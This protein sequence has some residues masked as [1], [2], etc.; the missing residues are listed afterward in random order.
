[1]R[2]HGGETAGAQ[3]GTYSLQLLGGFELWHGDEIVSLPLSAQRLAAFL[4]LHDRPIQRVRVA[5]MLWLET[6]EEQA[7]A[8]LRTALWRLRRAGPT[9]VVGTNTHLVLDKEVSVDARETASRAER[10]LRGGPPDRDDLFELAH[11]G[12]FLADWYDDWVVIERERM[13]QL[14]VHALERVSADACKDG[15]FAQAAEAG[16]AAVA[17][18]PLRESAH[19]VVIEAHL[20]EGN[21]NEALR[22]FELFRELLESKLGLQP[23]SLMQELM[24]PVTMR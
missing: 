23:S 21:L 12:E 13:R 4:A 14:C 8:S 16:L 19:R 5:G 10:V 11:A 17:F 7:N 2:E 18:E 22:Q 3:P 1:M 24:Q 6:S 9:L 20:A 15:H